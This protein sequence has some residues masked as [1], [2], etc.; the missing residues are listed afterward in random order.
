LVGLEL[1]DGVPS[2]KALDE[3]DED[4]DDENDHDDKLLVSLQECD[5]GEYAIRAG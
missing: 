5:L 4:A 1:F 3:A 2:I